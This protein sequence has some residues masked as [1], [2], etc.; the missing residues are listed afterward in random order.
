[1]SQKWQVVVF[2]N[3][4]RNIF[5]N[6]NSKILTLKRIVFGEFKNNY[7]NKQ[8]L[9][10]LLTYN[11]KYSKEIIENAL[12]LINTGISFSLASKKLNI[13]ETTLRNWKEKYIEDREFIINKDLEIQIL[14]LLKQGKN[15][16]QISRELN[17]DYNNLRTFVKKQL[18]KENY[19]NILCINKKLLK[20]SK[21]I[22]IELAY[23]LGVMFGD[24]YFGKGQI[25]LGTK[26][27]E[28]AEYFIK[29][30]TTWS[31][32]QP[33][34]WMKK[35]NNNDYYECYLSFKDAANFLKSLVKDRKR[36]PE[37]IKESK[38]NDIKVNFIKGFS[39]SEGTIITRNNGANFLK[40][41]NQNR[42]L[43]YDL[44][45][46]MVSLGFDGNKVYITFN[47]KAKNGDIYALRICYKDQIKL[48]YEKIG[49]I[50][51][52][53]QI[54][55]EKLFNKELMEENIDMAAIV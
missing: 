9:N 47:N 28:F 54:K 45:N 50:I 30:L 33:K 14:S 26:D 11:R 43:L 46:L 41:Y 22:S 29:I 24:G 7:L 12:Q 31:N 27:R 16:P 21:E 35:Q 5:S 55:L 13:P 10:S 8:T 39:D 23:I 53:K 19:S 20:K 52:R 3:I 17:I 25:R 6:L 51:K 15:I 36:I 48:F 32:K 18:T 37:K 34:I 42:E 1:M 4:E 40:I 44:R 38:I 49:F 2:I